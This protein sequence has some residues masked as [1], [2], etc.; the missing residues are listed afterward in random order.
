MLIQPTS[1]GN[2]SLAA[3]HHA[4]IEYKW[5]ELRRKKTL[6]TTD[7]TYEYVLPQYVDRIMVVW[8]QE[9]DNRYLIPMVNSEKFYTAF[10]D[11]AVE[12]VPRMCMQTVTAF[13]LA[14]PSAASVI[15]ASSSS[16]SD[17]GGIQFTIF[18]LVGGYP[19]KETITLDT[20]DS[21]TAVST[22]GSPTR[23]RRRR[24]VTSSDTRAGRNGPTAPG[25][26]RGDG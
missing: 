13:A 8:H 7:G 15:S 1:G 11:S 16:D 24:R 3:R 6:S 22:L 10:L 19:D 26:V 9:Y 4:N 17:T 25:G 23:K 5:E 21:T 20:S 12:A 2:N 14:Q 18:G